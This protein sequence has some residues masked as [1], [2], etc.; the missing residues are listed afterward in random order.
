LLGSGS[1]DVSGK[2]VEIGTWDQI[3]NT[4]LSPIHR[5]LS[6]PFQRSWR[7]IVE[8]VFFLQERCPVLLIRLQDAALGH[9]VIKLNHFVLRICQSLA[10]MYTVIDV[11]VFSLIPLSQAISDR[12]LFK[13]RR[14][15]EFPYLRFT[16]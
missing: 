14:P 3:Y 12:R 4:H 13:E 6:A 11:H 7:L 16:R 9:A 5:R 1:S 10:S 2:I 15:L 8:N